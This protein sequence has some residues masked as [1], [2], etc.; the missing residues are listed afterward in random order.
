MKSRI[1]AAREGA[2]AHGSEKHREE[3]GR[4]RGAGPIGTNEGGIRALLVLT[5]VLL[6]AAVR[7]IFKP[8]ALEAADDA[9][10]AA[11]TREERRAAF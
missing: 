2:G 11:G 1:W 7:T 5:A 6:V 3:R 8:V 10:D 4:A 9:V